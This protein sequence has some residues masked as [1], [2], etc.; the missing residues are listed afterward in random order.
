MDGSCLAARLVVTG[1]MIADLIVLGLAIKVIVAQLGVASSGNASERYL[2]PAPD[3]PATD[4]EDLAATP[5]RAHV[6]DLDARVSCP[7][8]QQGTATHPRCG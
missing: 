7:V 8:R 1:Q 6:N 5:G 4:T 3:K 2:F